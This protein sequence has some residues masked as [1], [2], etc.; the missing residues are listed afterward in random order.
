MR[1]FSFLIPVYNIP[2]ALVERCVDSIVMQGLDADQFEI[3]LVDDGSTLPVG[4]AICERY[5]DY[6]IRLIR[7]ENRG[8][9]GARNTALDAAQG[10]YVYCVD[11]DDYLFEM[12][13]PQLSELADLYRPDLIEVGYLRI[14]DGI[15]TPDTPPLRTSHHLSGAEVMAERNVLGA[16]WRYIARREFLLAKNIRF[17]ERL[18]HEDE[19]F[20]TLLLL[21]A[22][23]TILTNAPLYAYCTRA[24]STIGNSSPAHIE[25]RLRDFMTIIK[26]HRS[27]E[28]PGLTALQQRALRHRTDQLRLDFVINA[29]RCFGSERDLAPWLAEAH[30]EGLLPLPLRGSMRYKLAALASRSALGRSAIRFADRRRNKQ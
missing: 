28:A 7:Q 15:V 22:G 13:L 16:P 25:R 12:T 5:S 19:E 21:H 8:P 1:R 9:G 11:A 10:E 30:A 3:I 14:A 6:A 27:L 20:V 18:L 17:P 2:D 4:G 29:L 24:Q 26:R 23:R